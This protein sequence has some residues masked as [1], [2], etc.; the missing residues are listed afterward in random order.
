MAVCPSYS[1]IVFNIC[2]GISDATNILTISAFRF[3]T[4]TP[5]CNNTVM[6]THYNY[7]DSS[8]ICIYGTKDS[9]SQA[10]SSTAVEYQKTGSN[11][12]VR[13][14]SYRFEGELYFYDYI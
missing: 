9:M 1:F 3:D 5:D 11:L 10:N 12:T 7:K 14:S 6:Y 2:S 8:G 4:M 13:S